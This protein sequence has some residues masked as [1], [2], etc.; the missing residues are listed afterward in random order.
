M[1]RLSAV[2]IPVLYGG[3]DVK[4]RLAARVWSNG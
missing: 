2:G 4:V 1:P 3:E